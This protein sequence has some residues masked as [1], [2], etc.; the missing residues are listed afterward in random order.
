MLDE[1]QRIRL[2]NVVYRLVVF[3]TTIKVM[4][5]KRQ[6]IF[7]YRRLRAWGCEVVVQEHDL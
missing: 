2:K 6:I 4:K 1:R 5:G 3:V 7:T